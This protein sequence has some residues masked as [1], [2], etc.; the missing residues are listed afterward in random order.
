[1]LNQEFI[2]TVTNSWLNPHLTPKLND[3][4][5]ASDGG[6]RREVGKGGRWKK[7]KWEG[8]DGG[9]KKRRGGEKSRRRER[10]RKEMWEGIGRVYGNEKKNRIMKKGRKEGRRKG[11][12]LP[13]TKT[14]W[15]KTKSTIN[16]PPWRHLFSG[17]SHTWSVAGTQTESLDG[18][19]A[20]WGCSEHAA[21]CDPLPPARLNMTHKVSWSPDQQPWLKLYLTLRSN[22]FT[23]MEASYKHVYS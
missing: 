6:E 17:T 8:R 21:W 7:G 22:K 4:F 13:K 19:T 3:F 20:S 16:S 23:G 15:L 2:T 18:S 14:K 5:R 10:K 12:S 1:M 11:L 9:G